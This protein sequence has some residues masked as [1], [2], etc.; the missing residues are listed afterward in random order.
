MQI[1]VKEG[2]DLNKVLNTP[3]EDT[4][5]VVFPQN[6]VFYQKVFVKRDNIII[7]GNNSTVVWNDHNGMYEGFGTADSA[8][9]TI[10]SNHIK[11]FNLTFVNSFDYF[12]ERASRNEAVSKGMG[13]Q[14]VALYT[15]KN[16]DDI[17]FENCS[18]KGFQDTLF[19]DG[20]YHEFVNCFISGNVDFIFGKAYAVFSSCNI[21]SVSE[22]IIAA[23]S[24]LSE[25]NFGLVFE[26]C[27][28]LCSEDVKPETVYL[29]RP[30]HPGGRPGVCSAFTAKN[31]CFGKHIKNERWTSMKDSK[32]VVHSPT[33][34]R[35]LIF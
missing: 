26:N 35:F 18:F 27:S 1:A 30:W 33:E 17:V 24:T 22:G 4:L 6:A 15:A 32:G 25:S 16:A 2:D 7:K 34:S 28:F 14:A 31:C 19:A 3:S 23:P 13:L 10:E 20:I 5:E 8:S 21:V 9:F 29:A 12:A 11:I